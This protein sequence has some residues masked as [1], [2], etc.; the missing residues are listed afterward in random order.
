MT[1]IVGIDSLLHEAISKCKKEGPEL[2]PLCGKW[3]LEIINRDDIDT[4]LKCKS[5]HAQM[6]MNNKSWDN[7]EQ[8]LIF[9]G[10]MSGFD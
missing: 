5:C 9:L 6:G 3:T 2:C 8:R 4:E 7:F 1:R 10:M